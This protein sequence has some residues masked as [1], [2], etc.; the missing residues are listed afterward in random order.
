MSKKP[1][2]SLSKSNRLE[3]AKKDLGM[4]AGNDKPVKL[5]Q[6][7]INIEESLFFAAKEVALKRKR[8][9]IEPN[10]ITA[11]IR[12]ALQKIVDTEINM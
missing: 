10:T 11:M 5:K 12:D 7:T 2:L 6:T 1:S 3:N 8:E 4:D 9:G